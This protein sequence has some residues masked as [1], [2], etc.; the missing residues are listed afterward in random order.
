MAAGTRRRRTRKSP[1]EPTAETAGT[2]AES[3]LT[4]NDEAS[5]AVADEASETVVESEAG[6]EEPAAEGEQDD[7]APQAEPEEPAAEEKP[8]IPVTLVQ[9]GTGDE[10]FELPDGSTVFDLLVE[11]DLS[12]KDGTVLVNSRHAELETVLPAGATVVFATNI[13][14][15]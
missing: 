14:G 5:E 8:D 3:V 15:G 2:G 6:A 4:P 1:E 12:A 13:Q 11:A 10:P 9:M 7:G